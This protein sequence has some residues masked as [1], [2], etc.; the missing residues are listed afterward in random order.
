VKNIPET[1]LALLENLG[2]LIVDCL[3]MERPHSTHFIYDDIENLI[4]R[5]NPKKVLA[6]HICHDIHYENDEKIIDKRMKFAYD[7]QRIVCP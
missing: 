5:I 4:A 1:S 6:T 2:L 3:R 7:G